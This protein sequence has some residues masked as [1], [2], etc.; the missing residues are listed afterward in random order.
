MLR[1]SPFTL[2][3][4]LVVALAFWW[5]QSGDDPGSPPS[6]QPD[7]VEG[8]SSAAERGP[9]TVGPVA[10][11]PAAPGGDAAAGKEDRGEDRGEDREGGLPRVRLAALPPEAAEV[12]ALIDAGGPY[13]HPEKD[14]SRFGNYEELLPLRPRG[15]YREYTVPTPGLDHRGARRIVTGETGEMYWTDDH[16][17][18]FARIER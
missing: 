4:A 3:A 12:V 5:L 1:R 6:S 16:Y 2:L 8:A 11:P 9:T 17:G 13:A 18:S 7:A 14:G 15:H 10:E